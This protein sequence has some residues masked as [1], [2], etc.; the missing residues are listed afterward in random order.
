[1]KTPLPLFVLSL[2]IFT[3]IFQNTQ[4][5]ASDVT[6]TE[7]LRLEL[8]AKG[9]EFLRGTQAEDG[10][11]SAQAGVGPT[12][13]A[14]VGL[15]RSG[16]DLDDPMVQRGMTFLLR[17]VR[18]DGGVYTEA[19]TWQ[20]YE[21]SVALMA[22]AAANEAIE[23][24]A[25][26]EFMDL[27]A[28]PDPE[29]IRL[30]AYGKRALENSP[31]TPLL[32]NA[33]RFIRDAQFTGARGISIDDPFY[34]GAGYGRGRRPDLSN[35]Q[36]FLDALIAAGAQP[37][38]PA[39]QSALV[40]VSRTQN[41]ESEHNTLPFAARN[42]DGGFIYSAADQSSM[43]GYVIPDV[44]GSGLKSYGS[45]T[46]AGFK[47]LIY[48]GLTEEDPRFRAALSWL[49]RHYTLDE[50][51]ELGYMGLF[52]YYQTMAKTLRVFGRDHFKD[53]DGTQHDWRA[54]MI[55]ML[56]ERQLPNGAWV[57]AQQSRWMEGDPNLV[58]AYA[59]LALAD[60]KIE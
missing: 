5:Q 9:T 47:S 60:C 22:F 37:D 32:R 18:S 20:N 16:T 45:M 53:A 14:V 6:A 59:L 48:A 35:T 17:S 3:G 42:P 24:R 40:F 21:T 30:A 13:L 1:M 57:N 41:L 43:A 28:V 26:K 49:Q 2:L 33:E 36:F 10:T 23:A 19:G 50:N 38:D 27:N 54:D 7:P 52:Y 25:R 55:H 46:Y 44:P 15:L 39:I 31:Y 58:T 8:I 29:G 11:W 51:P 56:A 34:G 12:A 4:V